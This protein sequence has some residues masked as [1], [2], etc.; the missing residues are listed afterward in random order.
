MSGSRGSVTSSP[1]W[2]TRLVRI[3]NRTRNEFR[4]SWRNCTSLLHVRCYYCYCRV[5]DYCPQRRCVPFTYTWSH[6]RPAIMAAH[7]VLCEF[8]RGVKPFTWFWLILALSHLFVTLIRLTNNLQFLFNPWRGKRQAWPFLSRAEQT[9][10]R[11]AASYTEI[12]GGHALR[13][14]SRDKKK[15]F[16]WTWCVYVTRLRHV[17]QHLYFT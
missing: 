7:H 6:S 13:S 12:Y 15:T 8:N 11:N 4:S 3:V 9:S 5:Y 1:R 14:E 16:I 10:F 2:F 17:S